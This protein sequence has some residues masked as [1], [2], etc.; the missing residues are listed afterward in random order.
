MDQGETWHG[1][2]PRP[3][4]HCVTWGPSF[5]SFK[6]AQL[7][8]NFQP[9]SVVAIG[10]IDQ[11]A[12]CYEG[13][14]R[15]RRHC[16]RWGTQLL[17][18]RG[19]A[20]TFRPMSIVAK[21]SP[22]SATAEHLFKTGWLKSILISTSIP[23]SFNFVYHWYKLNSFWWCFVMSKQKIFVW[24]CI[25]SISVKILLLKLIFTLLLNGWSYSC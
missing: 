17:L 13:K 2:R 14:P 4:P 11:D 16:V 6:G 9:M 25:Y 22:I 10:W 24:L 3:W 21:R 1:G 18:K 19:T 8:P 7:S 23:L 12:T 15:S 20:P 5:P